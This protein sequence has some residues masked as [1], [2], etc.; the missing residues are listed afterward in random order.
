M[1]PI[2][3]A[4]LQRVVGLPRRKR[5]ALLAAID[6]VLLLL[7]V[8]LLHSIRYWTLFVPQSVP[9]FA[10]MILGPLLTVGVFLVFRV[11]H[12]VARYLGFYGGLRL[13]VCVAIAA[14]LWSAFLLNV[15]QYGIPRSVVLAYVPA[16]TAV[17][18]LTRLVAAGLLGFIGIELRRPWR[19]SQGLVP[20]LIYGTG[21]HA[22][23]LGKVTRR[24]KTRKLVG[25]I[26]SSRSM[27]GRYIGRHKVYR[28]DKIESLMQVHGVEEIY[29][30]EPEQAPAE[31]RELLHKLEP[32]K[33][34]VRLLPDM[35]ALALG[36]VSLNQLR[37]LEGRDLL[38]REE[39]PPDPLLVARAIEGKCVMVTGAGG[40]IG[41]QLALNA[42]R[43]NPRRIILLEQSELAIFNVER[44]CAS[45]LA[46]LDS[47]PEL[48][49]VL[50]SV[51][52]A[53]LVSDVLRVHGVDVVFHAAAY[54][55]VPIV[56]EHP[57]AGISNNV[58]ATERL[59]RTCMGY[60]VE[61]FV[62]VSSDKAVRP[63][64]VMGATKRVAELIV[65][66]LAAEGGNTIFTSVR[67]GNVLESSGSVFGLFEAQIRAGGP[68][69]VT[70]PNVVRYFMSLREAC[71]LVLQASAMAKGGE[72]FVL[73]MGEPIKIDALAR[74]MIRLMGYEERTQENP[75]GDIEITYVGL[76]P[77]EKLVEELV[78]SEQNITGTQHPRIWQAQEPGVDLDAL[79]RE[80][81]ALK[82]SV[83][84]RSVPLA[85]ASL[86]SIVEG[87]VPR[88]LVKT[89]VRP[90]DNKVTLH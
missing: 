16:G 34:R 61:R 48:I 30:A 74:S 73:D 14:A 50:G 33:L 25:Y 4:A 84:I 3:D 32:F 5:R 51:G 45:V 8:W 27:A 65:Q 23:Q 64:N 43:Y 46:K 83:G 40:S 56:E 21:P 31:R 87:Y 38:G 79:R 68:V 39:V 72:T 7:T 69:T 52:D 81:D 41:S 58:L 24:S 89:E 2:I 75:D 22:V 6:F 82:S 26:D 18:V 12:L 35:E 55:H 20:V 47:P 54:K 80:I 11:Y 88:P 78:L 13:A 9:T 37:G 71:N 57:L 1:Y 60:G 42:L 28:F 85:L 90:S 66:S 59:A 49:K 67:F 76:R 70:D 53:S 86:E 44:E 19:R 63:T 15:G 29:V 62:L 17:V 10:L 77:G 36:R